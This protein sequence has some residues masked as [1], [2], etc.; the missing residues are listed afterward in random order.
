MTDNRYLHLIRQDCPLEPGTHV[1]AYCRD[2]GG[3]EQDRSVA[4][5]IE[6]IREY[7]AH[8][9][10]VLERIYSDESRPGSSTEKRDRL[11]DM[12]SDFS[13]RFKQIRS[14]EKRRLHMQKHPFGVIVW[15]SNRLGRDSIE[16]TYIKAD[17]RIR[18]ITIVSLISSIET[19]DAQ[20]DALFEVVQ[21]YQDEKLL[22]EISDNSR[23][24][25]AELVSL[26]D[27]D[28]TFRLHNPDWPTDDG[29]YLGIMPGLLPTGFQAERILIGV[30]DRKGRKQGGEKHYVQRMIP[31]H[32][33]NLWERCYLAWKM[34]IEGAGIKRILE[35]TRL[36]N[37]VSGYDHFFENRIYTGDLEYGGKLYENFVEPLIPHEWFEEEQKRRAERSAKLQRRKADPM[38]EPRRVASRHLLTG[39]VYCGAVEGEEHPMNADTV[40]EREGKRS[41]WDFYICTHKKNSREQRCQAPRVGAAALDQA[42]IENLMTHVLTLDNLRPIADALA[43]SLSERNED[44]S[45]RIVAVQGRLDEVQKSIR[46]L[47]DAVEKIGFSTS[48]QARLQEREQEERELIAELVNLEDL[49]VKQKDIPDVSDQQLHEWIESIRVAI[50]GENIEL[51]RQ[52]IRQFV[53]KIVVHEKAG[54]LFYTFPLSDL[55]RNSTVAP[56]GLEPVSPP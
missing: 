23:R 41:R 38:L 36:F 46:Q 39:L 53:A 5:Q 37:S 25:L 7:C 11:Q 34:R 18:G 28:P 56:T 24:G 27:N 16:T 31:N 9:G 1:V 43:T 42:V 32:E 22:E 54:T 13:R 2:S 50:T 19:G 6:T 10:L 55:S 40:P 52:A 49:I 20:I 48:L 47:V 4:Q 21:Q 14:M 33:D 35:A 44:V 29:R 51:A 15:K 3:E 17:M 12:L 26:R 30:R 8:H 45:E